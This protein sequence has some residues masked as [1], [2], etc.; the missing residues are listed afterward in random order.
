MKRFV[1]LGLIAG[2][3]WMGEA[4]WLKTHFSAVLTLFAVWVCFEP[5][6]RRNLGLMTRWSH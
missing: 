5:I 1:I 6:A 3:V 2:S 4:F